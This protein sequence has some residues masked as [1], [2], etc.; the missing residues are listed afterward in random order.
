MFYLRQKNTQEKNDHTP[1]DVTTPKQTEVATSTVNNQ[2]GTPDLSKIFAVT[3][4]IIC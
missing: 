1:R 3:S 4:Q 2:S